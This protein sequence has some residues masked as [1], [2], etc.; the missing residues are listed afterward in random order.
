MT[1]SKDVHSMAIRLMDTTFKYNGEYYNLRNL[2]WDFEYTTKK[3]SLGSC[4]Y[5]RS[6]R[7]V[8]S[9]G[10]SKW[11]ILNANEP[12]S[13]WENVML[14]EIAHA[15]DVEIR[16]RSDHSWKWKHIARSIGC[17]AERTTKVSYDKGINSK[18]TLI[19]DACGHETPSHK[20]K[21]R[22]CSCGECNPGR[23]DE[24]FLLR[25][26]QNY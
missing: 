19:C 21:R 11:L 12:L 9:I 15:I 14:H 25:Q 10:L 7:K 24:R 20:I 6:N 23:Y 3:R 5:S 4:R 26:V 1:L 2:N 8:R 13:T 18:Y 16:G 17:D 22:E